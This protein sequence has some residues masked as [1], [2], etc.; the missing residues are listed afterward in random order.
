MTANTC[1][2]C[3]RQCGDPAGGWGRL[4]QG[5]PVC[6]PN[7]P[8]RPDCF[9]LVTRG[10]ETLGSRLTEVRSD[11]VLLSGIVGSTAYGLAL[12]GSDVDQLGV[13]A[14]PTIAFHG[15]NPPVGKNAS[16]VTTGATEDITLH[17]AGK[18]AA[19]VLQM[20]PTVTELL[21]LD[22]YET[23]T[24]LGDQLLELRG[25]FLSAK[26]VRSAYLGYAASQFHRLEARGD[27]SFSAD[28]R[29]RTAKHA[30][31]LARLIHQG[32]E[33]YRTGSLTIRLA[34]PDWYHAFGEQV[35][36]GDLGATQ[37]L[38]VRAEA[39]FDATRTPL[40]DHPDRAAVEAWLHDVRAAHYTPPRP[41]VETRT[42]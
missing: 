21:W 33:L 5:Q 16:R 35:A 32:L 25:A 34:D 17:E 11:S 10:E 26:A 40:P 7:S 31:H 1:A 27:G 30:R 23:R 29:K 37:T 22:D 42:S 36:N 12:P 2:H 3:G 39:D 18:Y 19:L 14:T 15:L 24:P 38:L 9:V 20:N 28:T 8:D 13:Y 41:T 4:G 6:H